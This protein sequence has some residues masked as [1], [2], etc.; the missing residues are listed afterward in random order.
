MV[1]KL[2]DNIVLREE[3]MGGKCFDKRNGNI[4]EVD[5]ELYLILHK[6]ER[7]GILDVSLIEKNKKFK[8]C[9]QKLLKLGILEKMPIGLLNEHYFEKEKEYQKP[10]MKK[11]DYI[12]PETIHYAVTFRCNNHCKDC[13]M[14]K[15]ES[16]YN[17]EM[18]LKEIRD[19]FSDIKNVGIFQLAIGG[20]EPFLKENLE[21]IFKIAYELGFVIHVTTGKYNLSTKKL[22]MIKKYVSVLQIGL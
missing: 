19:V 12:V 3:A 21:S 10:T 14:K 11:H 2:K 17:E 9:I 5:K 22:E 1:V 20:G 6:M 16:I 7:L 13:Y 15:H 4:I 8:Q 18:S